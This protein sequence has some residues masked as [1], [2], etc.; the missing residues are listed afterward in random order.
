MRKTA[1]KKINKSKEKKKKSQK[2]NRFTQGSQ[3]GITQAKTY[4]KGNLILFQI[5][6]KI[7]T[8][9]KQRR[10]REN[11]NYQQKCVCAQHP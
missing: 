5:L 1:K 9:K 6:F 2:T 3:D 8:R 11:R 7:N 4:I 10:E